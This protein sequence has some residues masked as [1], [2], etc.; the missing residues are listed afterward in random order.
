MDFSHRQPNL[1]AVSKGMLSRITYPTGGYTE[2][3]LKTIIMELS[4]ANH[5]IDFIQTLTN[6]QDLSEDF[7]LNKLKSDSGIHYA[8]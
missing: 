2:L 5:S 1:A 8:G 3:T 4:C 6:Y 7:V